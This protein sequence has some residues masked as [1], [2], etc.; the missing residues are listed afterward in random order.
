MNEEPFA[1]SEI[2]GMLRASKVIDYI[3]RT[4]LIECDREVPSARAIFMN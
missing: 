4:P 2:Q 1:I 3:D